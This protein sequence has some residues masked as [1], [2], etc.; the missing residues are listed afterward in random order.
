MFFDRL[1]PLFGFLP[2]AFCRGEEVFRDVNRNTIEYQRPRSKRRF[3]EV[4]QIETITQYVFEVEAPPGAERPRR[5]PDR[6]MVGYAECTVHPDDDWLNPWYFKKKKMRPLFVEEIAVSPEY[7]GKGV[8]SFILDQLEHIARLRGCTHVMLQVSENNRPALRW[9]KKRGL[10]KLDAGIFLAKRLSALQEL[11]PP[12]T[13]AA[14]ARGPQR[15]KAAWGGSRRPHPSR[16]PAID[17]AA[18]RIARKAKAGEARPNLVAAPA[19]A[20]PAAVAARKS[21]PPQAPAAPAQP[22]KPRP[23]SPA[24]H[25]HSE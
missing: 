23:A 4:Y 13:V 1:F 24:V 25:P 19:E 14:T 20:K 10:R 9:Y 16:A 5:R 12:K 2:A 8:G 7:Q 3:T 21:L 6:V 18:R 11:L 22:A 17:A 15:P